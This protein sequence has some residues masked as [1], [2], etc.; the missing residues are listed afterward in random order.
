MDEVDCNVCPQAKNYADLRE[1][2]RKLRER[3][4]KRDEALTETRLDMAVVK[5]KVTHTADV[6][7][8]IKHIVY[9]LERKPAQNW[10][11]LMKTVMVVVVTAAMTL[12]LNKGGN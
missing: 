5:E 11:D 12:L 2:Q 10:Q 3:G 1:E 6:V 7:T 9:G 8:D 4:E